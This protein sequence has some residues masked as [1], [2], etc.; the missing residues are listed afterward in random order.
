MTAP[1]QVLPGTIY[2]LTR[3]CSERRF[4]LR[5]SD[6]TTA[7]FLYL[8]AVAARLYD[9]EVHAFCVMSNHWH[10]VVT[11][12]DARLPAF[13]QYLDSLVARAVNVSIGHRE[14]FWGS[15]Y[16][17]VV[18]ESPEDVL[19]KCAYV[20]ANPVA[21]G[22]VCSGREW[23]GL[24]SAPG[25]IGA[26]PFVA[27][28]PTTFFRS[29]GPMPATAELALVTPRGF[30]SADQF[31]ELLAAALAQLEKQARRDVSAAG[32]DF[33]GASRVKAQKPWAR[34]TTREPQRNLDPRVAAQ[35][36]WKRIEA[37]ARLTEFRDAYR[38]AWAKWRAGVRDALFPPGTYLLRVSHAALCAPA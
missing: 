32:R 20:L 5:P 24:W 1:R 4:F 10:L 30:A 26:N 12:R 23:P 3:R 16:S 36:K 9:I 28:R 11:D 17:A 38:E 34:P 21:A 22:L 37:L 14:N 33:L 19:A 31:R 35:D 13:V 18:L 8:L 7:I 15:S 29:E 27:R 2:L 25:R 6:E